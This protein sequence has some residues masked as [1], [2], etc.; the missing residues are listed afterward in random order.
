MVGY[1]KPFKAKLIMNIGQAIKHIRTE[2]GILQIELARLAGI[3]TNA[4]CQIEIGKVFPNKNAVNSICEALGI[5]QSY[6]LFFSIEEEDM[7]SESWKFFKFIQPSISNLLL[8]EKTH[9]IY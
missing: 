8:N 5:P 7:S 6:L 3:S 9:K 2:K 4:L 1:E